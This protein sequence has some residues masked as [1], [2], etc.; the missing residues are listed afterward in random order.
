MRAACFREKLVSLRPKLIDPGEVCNSITIKKTRIMRNKV[1]VLFMLMCI[2]FT[3]CL[4]AANLLE[5]KVV[6]VLGL[7]F[8]AG[9]I[10]FPVSYIINDCVT[11]V[12]GYKKAS[13]LIWSGFAANFLVIIFAK[14]AVMLPAASF[15]EGE[16]HFNFVFGLAPRIAFASLLAFLTGSFINAYVMSRMKVMSQ[17]RHFSFRAI[18][19]TVLGEC[20]DSVVFFPIAFGGLMPVRELA[21]MMLTQVVLKSLYEV[22]ILPVTVRVVKAVKKV[23]GNDVYDTGISYNI[24]KFS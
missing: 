21:V 1:S 5:A 17:G 7:T 15:W 8:T 22:V 4:I 11:E 20:A 13:I 6:N 10:V 3:V 19:S 16:E 24:F 23:E 2:L 14:V 18:V 9:M 12:W